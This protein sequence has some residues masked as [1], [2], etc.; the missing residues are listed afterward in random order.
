MDALRD[1]I[2]PGGCPLVPL[3]GSAV[4]LRP[5]SEVDGAAL[6]DVAAALGLALDVP[7]GQTLAYARL[8]V[9][10]ATEAVARIADAIQSCD[11]LRMSEIARMSIAAGSRN[12]PACWP[13]G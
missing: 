10:H 11:C 12:N 7:R 13:A 5:S 4:W 8:D 9:E 3:A 1:A 2:G 6:V